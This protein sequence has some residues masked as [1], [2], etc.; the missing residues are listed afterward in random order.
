MRKRMR[1][2]KRRSRWKERTK[3][4]GRR[5]KKIDGWKMKEEERKKVS[6]VCVYIANLFISQGKF[7]LCLRP[8][9]EFNPFVTELGMLWCGTRTWYPL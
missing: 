6:G 8:V 2:R 5:R 4:R 3:K 1:R 9:V 7:F